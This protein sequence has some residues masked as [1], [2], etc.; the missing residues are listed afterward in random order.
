M[1]KLKVLRLF[2]LPARDDRLRLPY[3]GSL[4][5]RFPTLSTGVFSGHRYYARLRLPAVLL[6]TL[7]S[8][9]A[10][11]YLVRFFTLCPVSGSHIDRSTLCVPGLGKPGDPIRQVNKETDGSLKFLSY[12][13]VYM[14]RSWTPVGIRH[15][16]ISV[17]DLL[18]SAGNKASA[19]FVPEV[20]LWSTIIFIFE[21]L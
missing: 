18:P 12:P 15:L 5:H 21:A 16:A 17:T 3:N 9:L 13:F 8:S 1:C 20:S 7:H 14:P 19:L 11:R 6:S 2:L 10:C 4:G